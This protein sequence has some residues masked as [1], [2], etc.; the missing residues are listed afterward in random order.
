MSGTST[1]FTSVSGCVS[2]VMT[3]G[4]ASLS[5]ARRLVISMSA[6][7]PAC[8][9]SKKPRAITLFLSGISSYLEKALYRL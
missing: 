4:M 7:W 1:P 9:P 3:V 2:K 6:A 5:A 8:T